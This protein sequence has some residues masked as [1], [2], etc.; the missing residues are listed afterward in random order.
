MRKYIRL[1]L[2]VGGGGRYLVRQENGHFLE[3]SE[4]QEY[5]LKMLYIFV[6]VFV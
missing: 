2:G 3:Y 4:M 1:G 5:T 6:G